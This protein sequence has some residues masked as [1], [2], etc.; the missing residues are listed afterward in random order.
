MS[1]NMNLEET[2]RLLKELS[3]RKQ[4]EEA[5]KE[6][7]RVKKNTLVLSDEEQ[8]EIEDKADLSKIN[9][10]ETGVVL[11]EEDKAEIKQKV[12]N[13]MPYINENIDD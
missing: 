11:N 12:E 7:E 9:T 8:K 5:E 10:T 1:F 4:I 3:K 6:A 2:T 13:L